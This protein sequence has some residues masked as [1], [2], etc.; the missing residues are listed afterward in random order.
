MKEYGWRTTRDEVRVP[1]AVTDFVHFQ[2]RR[3]PKVKSVPCVHC[4]FFFYLL[5][6]A[7]YLQP[8]MAPLF[9]SSL[10]VD[11]VDVKVTPT[12]PLQSDSYTVNLSRGLLPFLTRCTHGPPF[13]ET[14][15]RNYVLNGLYKFRYFLESLPLHSVP[16]YSRHQS[17]LPGQRPGVSGGVTETEEVPSALQ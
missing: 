16:P 3:T 4:W 7:S 2:N 17:P 13:R 15:F 1:Y 12:C 8:V 10:H 9:S 11:S 14:H 5:F 6:Y